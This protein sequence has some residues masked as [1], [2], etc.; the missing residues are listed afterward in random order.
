VTLVRGAGRG[1]PAARIAAA[2]HGRQILVS[3]ATAD[4]VEND[5]TD[6]G[7]ALL[8]AQRRLIE[9]LRQVMAR[10]KTLVMYAWVE[11]FAQVR[12]REGAAA[13]GNQHCAAS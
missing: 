2:A 4:L 13:H 8:G 6:G 7:T 12:W 5:L 1:L 9:E 10:L 3:A 11:L